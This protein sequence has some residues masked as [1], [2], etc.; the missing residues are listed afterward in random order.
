[1]TFLTYGDDIPDGHFDGARARILDLQRDNGAIPWYDGG[2]IDPWNHTEA[3]MGLTVIGETTRARLAFQYLQETQL[4]DGSWWG[5]LGSAVPFD[6]EAHYKG[7][8]EG[9]G[10]PIR[11]TNFAAYIATGAWHHFLI[12]RDRKWLAQIWPNVEAAIKWVVAH[13]S[14]HGDVRWAANDPHTP[15]NDALITG[16]SSI[17]KSLECA[18]HIANELRVS[19]H[20]WTGARVRLGEALREKPHRFDRTWESKA[21]YSMDWYYPVLAGVITGEAAR[22]RLNAKW[23]IFVAEGKG[24]RCV[25]DQPWVTIAE[26]AELTMAL[27]VAGERK[28]AEDMLA[29]QHQWRDESGAYW[30]GHQFEENVAWPAEKPAW[31]AAAVILATD[32]VTGA[33]PAS[34]LFAERTLAEAA[35]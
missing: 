35:E 2:V 30:M 21:R 28:K 4:E 9:A 10:K 22:R 12:T 18:I 6:D 34:R 25:S 17:Y 31:T 11:D 20:D 19:S 24:C 23:D 5:Q 13:Q 32:A 14:P 27:L 33:T 8:D 7:G 3:A 29:W 26:S 1:M 15:E 16:S